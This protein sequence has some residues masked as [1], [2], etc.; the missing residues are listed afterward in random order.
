MAARLIAIPRLL[1]VMA[2][3]IAWGHARVQESALLQRGE[4]IR[5]GVVQGNVP[6]TQKWDEGSADRIFSRYLAMTRQAAAQGARFIVW[7]EASLPYFYE[8]QP[9]VAN[10]IGVVARETHSF[11]LIGG[12]QVEDG[13]S[14]RYFNSS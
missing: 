12:D 7:P 8:R 13:A 1:L 2:G 10:A 4:P 11:L 5:V 14:P 6:Q 3:T 9:P